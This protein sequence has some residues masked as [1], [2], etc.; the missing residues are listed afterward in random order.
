M[1][2][3]IIAG[4]GGD[5]GGGGSANGMTNAEFI[6]KVS[7]ADNNLNTARYTL[8][9]DMKAAATES[10]GE[11]MDM[12]IIM[13]TSGAIDYTGQK[14]LMDIDMSMA[15][16]MMGMDMDID[17]GMVMYVMEDVMYMK[18]EEM[19]GMPA[20]WTKMAIPQQEDF[21]VSQDMISQQ[22]QLLE[23]SDLKISDGGRVNGIDCYKVEMTPDMLTLYE[24]MMGQPG[25]TQGMGSG[26]PED[27]NIVDLMDMIRDFSVTQWYAKDTFYPVKA[28]MYMEMVLTSRNAAAIL[29]DDADMFSGEMEMIIDMTLGFTDHNKPVTIELPA[30]ASS[31]IDMSGMIDMGSDW[32]S[33]FSGDFD[34]WSEAWGGDM[35]DDGGVGWSGDWSGDWDW[36]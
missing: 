35:V 7:T 11:S 24:A 23:A 30:E 17:M 22:T 34:E 32:S 10:F 4:C 2:I 9:M 21:W 31:A 26:L 8:V 14:M 29:G 3:T 33:D 13:D 12:D 20:Q 27:I 25:M 18:T 6:R 15:T 16:E 19:M 28:D 36:E 1:I 5:G